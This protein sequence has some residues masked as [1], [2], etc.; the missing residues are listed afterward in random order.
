[1][2]LL[3]WM[4]TRVRELRSIQICTIIRADITRFSFY[5]NCENAKS[6]AV[7][8]ISFSL[9]G[10]HTVRLHSWCTLTRHSGVGCMDK[11]NIANTIPVISSILFVWHLPWSGEGTAKLFWLINRI[12]VRPHADLHNELFLLSQ[13][14]DSSVHQFGKVPFVLLSWW[15]FLF[16]PSFRSFAFIAVALRTYVCKS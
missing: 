12:I 4:R 10:P 8:S 5:A 3:M 9:N 7:I 14:Q 13:T 11:M 16:W 1:M 6:K 15:L 2:I